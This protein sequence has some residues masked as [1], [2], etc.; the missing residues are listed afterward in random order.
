MRFYAQFTRPADQQAAA[1]IPANL[2]ELRKKERLLELYRQS[3][4]ANPEELAATLGPDVGLDQ[5]T[6]LA[7][8]A[9]LTV[10][11]RLPSAISPR[12]VGS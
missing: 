8:L 10:S 7:W 9:E 3:P 11:D 1:I 4:A 12:H 5:E 2:D 6:V